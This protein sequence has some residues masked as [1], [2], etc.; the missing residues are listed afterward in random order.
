MTGLMTLAATQRFSRRFCTSTR[1]AIK[2]PLRPV[3]CKL[4]LSR[5]NCAASVRNK[6]LTLPLRA[7]YVPP[8]VKELE[9]L[10]IGDR[11]RRSPNCLRCLCA[12]QCL[13]RLPIQR[14]GIARC[15]RPLCAQ[16]EVGPRGDFLSCGRSQLLWFGEANA[17]HIRSVPI[18]LRS[19]SLEP[20]CHTGASRCVVD[21]GIGLET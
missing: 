21:H 13:A 14:P 7:R 8:C 19:P 5:E 3:P 6:I 12:L 15:Y 1:G 18:R 4:R 9:P 16:A 2:W 20:A 11:Q 10:W 17:C